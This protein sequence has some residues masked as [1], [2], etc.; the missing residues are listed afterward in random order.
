[1]SFARIAVC[2]MAGLVSLFVFGSNSEV[3]AQEHC[4]AGYGLY[5]QLGFGGFGF[6]NTPYTLGQ[7]PVP[8]YFAL[9]PPVYYRAPVPRPYGYS[10]FAYPGHILTPEPVV[11]PELINNPYCAPTSLAP[12]A[13]SAP[14][15]TNSASAK[16]KMI[17]NP[18]VSMSS[19][20]A[21]VAVAQAVKQ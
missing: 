12:E 2:L 16:P 8:P 21:V 5:S 1:M 13:D 15:I 4:G 17:V 7:V 14:G 20:D 10:P 11:S 18:F 19:D 6:R 3:N 9:H